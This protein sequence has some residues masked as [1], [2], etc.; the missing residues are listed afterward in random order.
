[1]WSK[2][3]KSTVHVSTEDI[4]TISKPRAAGTF[5]RDA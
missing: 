4:Q 1:M 5:T 2:W 3:Y